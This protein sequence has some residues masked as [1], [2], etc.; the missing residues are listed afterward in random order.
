MTLSNVRDLFEAAKRSARFRREM[1]AL[2]RGVVHRP[3][4]H[5]PDP[6]SWP[7]TGLHAAWIGHATV[8]LK[9]EGKWILTDPVL[10]RKVGIRVAGH[11]VGPE[12]HVGPALRIE[13]LPRPDLLLISH[14]HFDHLDLPTLRRI[15]R[16]VPVV[17]A[18]GLGDLLKR[19]R[20]RTELKWGAAAQVAG[21]DVRA[22]QVKH[23]GARM[24]TDRH[25]GYNGFLLEFA[26]RR[27][28]FGGDTAM[29]DAFKKVT[30]PVD[31]ALM[32]IGAY[33]PWIANHASP[34][35]AWAMAVMMRSE[36]VMAIHHQTFRLSREPMDEPIRRLL[37]AAGG[38]VWRVSGREVGE[39]VA[40]E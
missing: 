20:H 36:R 38:D 25:R 26:G 2:E 15:P 10:S 16:D 19:F 7:D 6:R 32:P 22:L 9:L 1:K 21:I 29:T 37:A 3:A 39:S 34:E 8:L 35:E 31:L 13:E 27:V 17:S 40:I 18:T 12:R 5:H 23:W 28:V 33:D 4:P 14:A 24:I 30:G 11:T